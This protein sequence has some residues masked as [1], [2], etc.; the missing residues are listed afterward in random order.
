VE[1]RSINDEDYIKWVK[2]ADDGSYCLPNLLPGHY[3]VSANR[4]GY[5]SQF[6]HN[7]YGTSTAAPVPVN[8][9]AVTFNISFALDPGG[10]I[11]GHVYKADGNT[12]VSGAEVRAYRADGDFNYS[13]GELSTADGS[14]TIG[15]FPAGSYYVRVACPGYCTVY[16]IES[17][18][19]KHAVK[20]PVASS[21]CTTGIN[22][23]LAPSGTISGHIYKADGKTPIADAVVCAL[24]VAPNQDTVRTYSDI[25]GRY[26]FGDL[27]DGK[28]RICAE[29]PGYIREFYEDCVNADLASQI[30]V[31]S[32]KGATGINLN[33]NPGGSISGFVY[34]SDG[35]TPISGADVIA[36]LVGVDYAFGVGVKSAVDGSFFISGLASGQ[37]QV[38]A[39]KEGFTLEFYNGTYDS[40]KYTP[41]R[42]TAPR[43][44]GPF[45]FELDSG[46]AISGFIY[47]ADGKTPVPGASINCGRLD[48][49]FGYGVSA[50]SGNDGSYVISGL[51]PGSYRIEVSKEGYFTEYYDNAVDIDQAKPVPVIEKE[52]TSGISFAIER[53]GSI[54]GHIYHSDGKTPATDT[55]VAV[56]LVN[57]YTWVQAKT[58]SSGSYFFGDLHPGKYQVSV[59]G[60]NA[61]YYNNVCSPI[62]ATLIDINGD[63][64]TGIDLKLDDGVLGS[65]SGHIDPHPEECGRH[66]LIS[67]YDASTN[68]VVGV[69]HLDGSGD[70]RVQCLPP[71]KYLVRVSDNG[72]LQDYEGPVHYY[73]AQ[74]YGE[75]Y[76]PDQS[77]PVTVKIEQETP[78]IDFTMKTGATI[79]G[80]ISV[81]AGTS[82][83]RQVSVFGYDDNNWYATKPFSGSDYTIGGLPDGRYKVRITAKGIAAQ[84]YNNAP[85]RQTAEAVTIS[86]GG[87]V[88]GIDFQLSGD[89]T[90]PAVVSTSPATS[91]TG[92]PIDSSIRIEFS[93]D[94]YAEAVFKSF[95][96]SPPVVGKLEIIDDIL[97]L[98]PAQ[99]LAYK[100]TYTVTMLKSTFDYAQNLIGALFTFSF[101][102]EAK[103]SFGSPGGSARGSSGGGGG[104]SSPPVNHTLTLSGLNSASPLAVNG[105]SYAVAPASLTSAD[106]KLSIS[107]SQG[108][109]L[110]SA[111]GS[112][113]SS[114]S[115]QPAS[116]LPDPEGQA[117]ILGYNLGPEGAQFS[118]ALALAFFYNGISLPQGVSEDDLYLA[119]WDGSQW[120]KLQAKLDPAAKTLTADVSHF[121]TYALLAVLPPPPATDAAPA[122]SLPPVSPSPAG[123]EA[124]IPVQSQAA[125]PV[126]AS[127]NNTSVPPSG[128][129][130]E[131]QTSVSVTTSTIASIPA[132]AVAAAPFIP[133]ATPPSSELEKAPSDYPMLWMTILVVVLILVIILAFIVRRV[134][135]GQK[136]Q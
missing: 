81:P 95:N 78:N 19:T 27:P 30:E 100:T 50:L 52:T 112:L 90:P 43:T 28:Y 114:V 37:Y 128:A 60:Y 14:Y 24:P 124:S 88:T 61:I 85:H 12:P 72:G 44:T 101:T 99:P 8:A 70:Y 133:D 121:S 118:P 3:L 51:P 18:D 2:V 55:H 97:T 117:V 4:T 79:S 34:E 31:D 9:S 62:F 58:D 10:L 33:L 102:T 38:Y 42:V 93:E 131:V 108:T 77:T 69:D 105:L 47:E 130:A 129:V 98:K 16:Y 87:S 15:T 103:K 111:N 21:D 74:W 56:Q 134:R 13:A 96:I 23:T 68:E 115:A 89:T 91:A 1:A 75:K 109:S 64:E 107:V 84:W 80:H 83:D 135:S 29:S 26:Y 40:K 45:T 120:A 116:L 65:I 132:S 6:Y 66:W 106:G 113:L 71:G 32:L 36:T 67:A 86:D 11:T 126:T 76:Y 110:K 25:H 125:N 59:T 136:R 39:V 17:P 122:P 92:V 7:A 127:G 123:P 22:F 73:I 35:I 63:N 94:M 53:R 46:G 54:S 57:E 48:D 49:D 20:V 82:S 104:S 41:V 119:F 5:I